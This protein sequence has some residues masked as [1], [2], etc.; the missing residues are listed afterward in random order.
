M[1]S[2]CWKGCFGTSALSR[3]A[4]EVPRRSWRDPWRWAST[5]L[6]APDRDPRRRPAGT[7]VPPPERG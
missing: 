7:M 6:S 4:G 5:H 1:T 3:N 2:P